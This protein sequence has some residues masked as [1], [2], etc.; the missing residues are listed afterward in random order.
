MS[1]E[2]SNNHES[3]AVIERALAVGLQRA[4][5]DREEDDVTLMNL[6][7]FQESKAEDLCNFLGCSL[8]NLLNLAVNCAISSAKLKGVSVN[9]LE[10]YPK[11]LG[12]RPIKVEL[13]TKTY[14]KLEEADMK[15]NVTECAVV[16]I[17]LFHKNFIG[18]NQ[19]KSQTK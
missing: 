9:E 7:E 17:E 19:S 15:E 12:S 4:N 14:I 3:N 1:L 8:G 18:N 5:K 10:G 13:T 2:N 16:G 11:E 6:S